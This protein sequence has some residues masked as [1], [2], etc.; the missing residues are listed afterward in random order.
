MNH[1]PL[2]KYSLRP[3]TVSNVEWTLYLHIVK[4]GEYNDLAS[5]E[6][7]GKNIIIIF[8]THSL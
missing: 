1:V 2:F 5:N 7:I 4:D 8:K 6:K 3:N